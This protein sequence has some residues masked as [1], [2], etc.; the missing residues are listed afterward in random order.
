MSDEEEDPDKNNL[1]DVDL[2]EE[3]DGAQDRRQLEGETI[4]RNGVS[5]V[6]N[7]RKLMAKE[8]MD[9][10]KAIRQRFTN[11]MVE[12]PY[13]YWEGMTKRD[14][15]RLHLDSIVKDEIA[16]D[17]YD[18]TW[19]VRDSHDKPALSQFPS[20]L[21][22]QI[23]MLWS[24][25]QDK[26]W[27]PFA[28]HF[29]RPL[30]SNYF[31]RDYWGQDVSEDYYKRTR[32]E[33]LDRCGGGLLEDEIIR[34][35]QRDIEVDLNDNYLRLQNKDS[36]NSEDVPSEWADFTM[37]SPPYFDLEYYGPEDEQI[38][39]GSDDYDEF[40]GKLKEIMA[41]NFRILKEGRY[42]VYVV[43]DFRQGCME[44]GQ[45]LTAY[46]RD[47]IN[48]AEEVGFI[49]HDLAMYPTGVSGGMFAQQLV[50][51][52]ITGK[53]HEFVLVF[54]KPRTEADGSLQ[55][56]RPRGLQWDTYPREHIISEYGEDEFDKWLKDRKQRNLPTKRFEPYA[57]GEPEQDVDM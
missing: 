46:H 49:N 5:W 39:H 44:A 53:I 21:A 40:L 16:E 20:K 7:Y 12:Y 33:I 57:N 18:D 30:L 45:G 48:I 2:A 41:H 51:M 28:G 38:G 42:A 14:K 27:D 31:D 25:P 3:T 4:N 9:K 32:R 47:V 37:T 35:E 52:E 17:T 43:N 56:W 10:S 50:H 11:K 36:R 23:I 15:E 1:L 54:R 6:K 8:E 22:K 13:S 26:I 19:S 24:K 55:R 29:S 34:E